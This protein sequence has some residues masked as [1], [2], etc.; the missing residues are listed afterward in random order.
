M[1]TVSVERQHRTAPV[2]ELDQVRRRFVHRSR[3]DDDNP[4]H[5]VWARKVTPEGGGSR[6]TLSWQL[7][8][9]TPLRQ[10][11]VRIRAWQI[12]RQDAPG[13]LTALAKV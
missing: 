2:L 8:P 5:T 13:S 3:P 1:G 7:R 10:V 12:P 4:S 11:M 6:L 9:R